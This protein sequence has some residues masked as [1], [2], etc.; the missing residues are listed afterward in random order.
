MVPEKLAM[1]EAF[2]SSKTIACVPPA[3]LPV[4]LQSPIDACAQNRVEINVNAKTV[5]QSA[6]TSSGG[7]LPFPLPPTFPP[8]S[9]PETY[10]IEKVNELLKSA[11]YFPIFNIPNPSNPNEPVLVIPGVSFLMTAVNVNEELHRYEVIV[12]EP[13]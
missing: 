8:G 4:M 12:A 10:Q 7:K 2:L 6:P 3:T 9:N 13:G 1:S 11:A 5:Q